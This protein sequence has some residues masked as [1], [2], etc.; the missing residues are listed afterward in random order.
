MSGSGRE[1]LQCV[2]E[3]SRGPLGSPGLVGRLSRS[4]GVVGRL[5]RMSKVVGRN[6]LV[7]RSDREVL[8]DVRD[9]SEGP[10]GR[11]GVIG[12]LSQMSGIGRKALSDV[13]E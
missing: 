10:F 5:S 1:A 4:A 7:F 8:P 13:R 6:S 11:P 3:W 2:R 12:R 9:W